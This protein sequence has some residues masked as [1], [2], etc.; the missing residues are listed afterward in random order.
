MHSLKS[1]LCIA[2]DDFLNKF[3][4]KVFTNPWTNGFFP[5]QY[6]GLLKITI[7]SKFTGERQ[8]GELLELS[9]YRKCLKK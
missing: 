2:I 9:L 7:G 6:F 4:N 5:L 1:S 8:G 3:Q